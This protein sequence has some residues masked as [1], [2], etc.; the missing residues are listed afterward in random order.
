MVALIPLLVLGLIAWGVI[1][2]IRRGTANRPQGPGDGGDVLMYLLMAVAVGVFVFSLVNLGRAAFPGGTFVFDPERQVASALAGLVVSGPIA[3]FLWRRLRERR[4]THPGAAGWTVY[5][6]LVEAVFMTSFVIS[7]FGV[8]DWLISDGRQPSIPDVLVFGAVIVFHE[9]AIRA[10]PPGS[11]AGELPRVIGSAIG[12][13]ALIIGIGGILQWGLSEL[14]E[15]IAPEVAST[16]FEA[17]TAVALI[18]TGGPVWWYRWLRPWPTAPG[19]PRNAWTFLA[20]ATGLSTLLGTFT[21]VIAQTL[22]YLLTDETSAAGD[23][24]Q[25]LPVTLAIGIVAGLVWAHHRQRLGSERTDPVRAYEYSMAAV[26]LSAGVAATT[27]LVSTVF[28]DSAF[29]GSTGTVAINAGVVL[30]VGMLTWLRFWGRAQRAPRGIEATAPPRRFYL[31]GLG[32]IMALVG[33]GAL[34]ATLVFVFQAALGVE[35]LDDS[36]IPVVALF[37]TAGGVSWHLLRSHGADRA[38][39][40]S[41]EVIT[42]FDVT[43]VCSHPGMLAAQFPKQARVRV[44]YR[45]DD[46]GVVS[47]DLA[48]EIV[49]AVGNSS[50][51][52]W[53]D[54]TGFRVAPA[55]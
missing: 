40:A 5:L 53:V 50:S 18:L 24:F 11:D 52:V 45:S 20:A 13:V 46:L 33:A 38:L 39:T 43:V 3:F 42:P 44:I 15:Q 55:R 28:S 19:A 23:H 17:M 30:L 31:L 4:E 25:F 10:T 1:A 51:L 21:F 34:I 48:D 35:G 27:T 41:T 29:V 37:L 16:G 26:A 9:I 36:F 47:D 54:D 8:L 2:L 22:A 32:V 12:L 7:L 49:T 14:Y 6:S